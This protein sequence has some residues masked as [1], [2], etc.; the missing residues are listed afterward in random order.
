MKRWQGGKSGLVGSECQLAPLPV[1]NLLVTGL[2]FSLQFKKITNAYLQ[3]E[4]SQK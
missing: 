1:I 2:I 4:V 3:E